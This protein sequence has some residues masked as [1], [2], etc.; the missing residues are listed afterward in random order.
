MVININ[1]RWN[2]SFVCKC[3]GRMDRNKPNLLL[4]WT[5]IRIKEWSSSLSCSIWGFSFGSSGCSSLVLPSRFVVCSTFMRKSV[6]SG[7]SWI[8]SRSWSGWQCSILQSYA[9]SKPDNERRTTDY[10]HTYS[11]HYAVSTDMISS[12]DYLPQK[13]PQKHK[14]NFHS[15]Y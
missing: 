2:M 15:K 7:R 11:C 10:A 14:A 1:S 9:A 5:W 12:L 3:K 6:A 8:G 4:I 13:V